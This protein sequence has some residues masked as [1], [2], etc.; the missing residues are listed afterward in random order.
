MIFTQMTLYMG[1]LL[2]A[3]GLD[4][5]NTSRAPSELHRCISAQPRSGRPA[6]ICAVDGAIG[7]L[8]E[9]RTAPPCPPQPSRHKSTRASRTEGAH[10]TQ[11]RS[12]TPPISAPPPP[13]FPVVLRPPPPLQSRPH[14]R[15]PISTAP[16]ATDPTRGVAMSQNNPSQLLPSGARRTQEYITLLR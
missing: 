3:S 9:Y 14:R 16:T 6:A 10:P 12:K 2:M 4:R 7:R 15:L 5:P 8:R 13:S 11:R 1:F